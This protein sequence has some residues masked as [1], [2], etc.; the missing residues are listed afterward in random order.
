MHLATRRVND[1]IVVIEL[2]M[3]QFDGWVKE[4]EGGVIHLV[5]SY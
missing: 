5:H 4:E 3:E 1:A 2:I